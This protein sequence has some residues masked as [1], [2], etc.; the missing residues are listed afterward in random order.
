[1]SEKL[2]EK[3]ED[4]LKS[5][6]YEIV[7]KLSATGESS[8]YVHTGRIKRELPDIDEDTLMKLLDELVDSDKRLSILKIGSSFSFY[9]PSKSEI[10]KERER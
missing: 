9:M 5:E 8:G 7:K 1:M 10:L 6:I 2:H 3:T 4:K